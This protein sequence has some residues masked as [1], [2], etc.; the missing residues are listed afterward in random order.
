MFETELKP[1]E[2][3]RLDLFP[4]TVANSETGLLSEQDMRI[5]VTNNMV[6][7]LTEGQPHNPD[8]IYEAYLEEFSGNNRE[9]YIATTATGDT[10]LVKRANSCGCG[11]TLRSFFA[12]VGVPRR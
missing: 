7:V 4:A 12:Y 1:A 5:I 2:F 6:Y 3:I 11:N 8:I 10:L 9:G